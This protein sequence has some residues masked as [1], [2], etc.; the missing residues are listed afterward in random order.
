MVSARA[1]RR[2]ERGGGA[3]PGVE[4]ARAHRDQADAGAAQLAAMGQRA[5]EALGDVAGRGDLD[6][7]R[8][9][10]QI[11]EGEVAALVDGG[12][13]RF[14]VGGAGDERGVGDRAIVGGVDDDAGEAV[15]GARAATRGCR[16]GS[17]S[18]PATS[19]G[20]AAMR[21]ARR[22]TTK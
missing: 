16:G 6:D 7:E 10:R 11:L 3:A 5:R 4:D 9:R 17:R 18:G 20:A 1:R 12:G 21:R 13:A 8:A 2:V 19:A 15:I 14:A 22:A